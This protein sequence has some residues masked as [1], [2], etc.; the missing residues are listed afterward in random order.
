L[1]QV[2]DI[3]MHDRAMLANFDLPVT[4]SSKR[5]PIAREGRLVAALA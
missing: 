1:T 5:T 3:N 4:R 2:V